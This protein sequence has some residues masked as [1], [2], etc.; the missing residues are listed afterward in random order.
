MHVHICSNNVTL[1]KEIGITV[2][3]LDLV[4]ILLWLVLAKS[5]YM[6]GNHYRTCSTATAH[7]QENDHS[8]YDYNCQVGDCND[9]ER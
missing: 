5:S 2:V 9:R 1:Y 7:K 3:V 4:C 6:L 8:S